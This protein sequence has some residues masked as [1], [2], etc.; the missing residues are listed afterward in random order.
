MGWEG[1]DR[2]QDRGHGLADGRLTVSGWY[3]GVAQDSE[4]TLN[5]AVLKGV[6]PIIETYPLEQTEEAWQHQP[7]A[8]LR[9]VLEC[10]KALPK[11]GARGAGAA[12][13]AAGNRR[14]R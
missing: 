13:R 5:F 2:I 4:D 11:G 1:G 6:R 10:E 14:H 3:S 7:K 12:D 9:I 8:N